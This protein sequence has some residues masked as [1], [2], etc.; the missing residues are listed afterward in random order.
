MFLLNK[1]FVS[2]IGIAFVI[3]V[4]V[5]WLFLNQWL[6]HFVYHTEI[7]VFH[8]LLGGLSVLFITLLTVSWHTYKAASGNPVKVLRSE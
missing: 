7:F 4:P 2:W 8:F 6:E 3:A 5:S 1:Q